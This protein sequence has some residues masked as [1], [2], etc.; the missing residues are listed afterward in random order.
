MP[1][2]PE[3]RHKLNELSIASNEEVRRHTQLPD[4]GKEWMCIWSDRIR[5][6]TFDGIATETAR[7]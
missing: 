5:K 3:T 2:S 4:R 1:R 6:K 7:R